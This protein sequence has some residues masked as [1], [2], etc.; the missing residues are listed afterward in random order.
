MTGLGLLPEL[1]PG[2]WAMAAELR[3]NSRL[4]QEQQQVGFSNSKA[5]DLTSRRPSA[6]CADGSDC[7]ADGS[8]NWASPCRWKST[9]RPRALFSAAIGRTLFK[10]GCLAVARLFGHTDR[11][12]A[13]SPVLP[14]WRPAGPAS[15]SLWLHGAVNDALRLNYYGLELVSALDRRPWQWHASAAAVRFE[16]EVQVDARLSASTIFAPDRHRCALPSP[17]GA[18]RCFASALALRHGTAVRAAAGAARRGR[19]IGERSLASIRLYLRSPGEM[20][21]GEP[22]RRRVRFPPRRRGANSRA[23]GYAAALRFSFSRRACVTGC[24][25]G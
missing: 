12:A 18:S 14:T 16:T 13:T 5:E 8:A 2:Q 17:S 11:W 4:S 25:R 3:A 21:P 15:Q 9:A 23:N 1:R 10:R 20:R 24:R 7:R 6:A 22:P 19:R